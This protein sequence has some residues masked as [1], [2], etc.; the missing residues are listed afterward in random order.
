[1][2]THAAV[3]KRQHE[4]SAPQNTGPEKS[5]QATGVGL[6]LFMQ[7]NPTASTGAT[8]QR[9]CACSGSPGAN[10]EYAAC[11][12]GKFLQAKLAIGASDDPLEQEADRVA[13]QVLAM[14]ENSTVS[15]APPR[16]QRYTGQATGETGTAPASVDRVL[17]SS[18]R[19]LDATL[20]QDMEQRFG[21]DFSRVRVH[22]GSEAEQSARD[23]SAQAYTVGNNVVFGAGRFAPETQAGRRL[24]AHELT[25]VV[26]QLST[27][28]SGFGQNN[29][30]RGLSPIPLLI[31]DML[32]AKAH[33]LTYQAVKGSKAFVSEPTPLGTRLQGAGGSAEIGSQDQLPVARSP[34]VQAPLRR[35]PG[36]RLHRYVDAEGNTLP[37]P[38][39]VTW[40]KDKFRL[41]FQRIQKQGEPAFEC[42]VIYLGPHPADGPFIKDKTQ[43]LSTAIGSA[44]LK[45]V[46]LQQGPTSVDIDIFG[47]GTRVIRVA[48]EVR[49]DDRPISRGREHNL[50]LK[51]NGKFASG[52]SLWVLD[53]AASA[54]DIQ[55][56]ST[57]G[58]PGENPK[59]MYDFAKAGWDFR[60]DGDG[61]QYKELLVVLKDQSSVSPSFLDPASKVLVQITQISTNTV[62]QKQFD[63]P[64]PTESS[65]LPNLKLGALLPFVKQVS[66]GGSPTIVQLTTM[67]SDNPPRMLIQ[68]PVRSPAGS[69]YVV[70]VPGLNIDFAFPPEKSPIHT[71]FGAGSAGVIGNIVSVDLT[72]GAYRDRFRLT[73]QPRGTDA[74][75]LGLSPLYRDEPVGG[76]GLELRMSGPIRFQ[77]ILTG[78]TSLGLDLDGDRV[79]ELMLYDRLT[80][81]ESYDGGGP[82][83]SNRNH[84]VRIVGAAVGGEQTL[85]FSIRDGFP[86]RAGGTTAASLTAAANALAISELKKEASEGSFTEQLDA[87][88][89]TMVVERQKAVMAG[90]L[91]KATFD[92]WLALS[93]SI[94]Q[95]RPQKLP[96]DATLQANAAT[97]ATALNKAFAAETSSKT[98]TRF[99]TQGANETSNP[100]TGERTTNVG[101]IGRTTG[102]GP[103]LSAHISGGRWGAAFSAYEKLVGGLDSWIV[104]Q[105]KEKRGAHNPETERVELI[106]GRK[107]EMAALESKN[108]QRVLAVFQPDEKFSSEAGYVKQVPLALYYWRDGNTWYLKN[109]T[110]PNRTYEVSATAKPGD[111]GP[112]RALLQELND[113]DRLPA[114]LIFYDIPGQIAGQVRTT[115][116]LTWAKAFSYLGLALAAIG[117]TLITA[118]G[119][120]PGIVVAGSWVLAGSAVAGAISAGIDL[121]DK[122]KHGDLTA[123]AAVLDIAQIVAGLAG[124]SALASGRIAVAAANVPAGARWAGNWARLAVLASKV[125][126][127]ATVTAA[128]ADVLSFA[129]ISVETAKQLDDIEARQGD[130]PESKSRAKML[131]LAQVAAL[132]GVNALLVKG[133]VPGLTRGRTLVLSPGPDGVPVATLALD[134]GSTVI[135]T[136]AAIALDLRARGQSLDPGHKAA[137]K[138]VEGFGGD[139]RVA[140]PTLPEMGVKGGNPTQKGVPIAVERTSKEYEALL[141]NLSDA[142]DPV[143]KAKG[144]ADRNIVADTFFAIT[145]PGVI[146]R[147]ATADK[148]IYNALSRRAGYDPMAKGAGIAVPT[149][150]PNGFEVTINR[151]T[152]KVMPIK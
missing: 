44:T 70:Q 106:A 93:Q 140:D 128:G 28:G 129:I 42:A 92:A 104:D 58:S 91:S 132:A 11:N 56:A 6:P 117:L 120:T 67:I 16:I 27:G 124:A 82:P 123:T 57:E 34:T 30:N 65:P 54:S 148:N 21:H 108:A 52:I 2:S 59:V 141:A 88:E 51:V 114:G 68:P 76:S 4:E 121:A 85:S 97:Q 78:E 94:I 99:Y 23:V 107:R 38:I 134:A 89:N 15:S 45:S 64:E 48:D 75:T 41:E 35:S 138:R 84:A 69:K 60:I 10:D 19:P 71:V 126:V 31:G 61:D 74:A 12:S 98:S 87:Y 46:V 127:P 150:F 142:S 149:K 26:Q 53:P 14:P 49:F 130:S 102:A 72:L 73:I 43:R 119:A 96:V 103:E 77:Q 5:S 63:V 101:T 111:T 135:D 152:I 25:H 22:S 9:K 20:Q 131:L 8:L 39:E 55:P 3:Q 110:N 1:M 80:T 145:E 81:P 100:Y 37:D 147:F 83:E 143:G 115:D 50:V 144:V 90:V 7:T 32:E 24:L 146:P 33:G 62:L 105:L 112:P 86:T 40:A 13:D 29:C 137:I 125:Y 136:N 151:H 17:A 139:L 18:G 118:G 113:P 79:P 122:V 36:A 133:L 95:L 66:D 116:G 109:I 47:D